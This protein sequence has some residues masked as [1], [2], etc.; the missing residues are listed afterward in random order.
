MYPTIGSFR[1]SVLQVGPIVGACVR[2]CVR[3]LVYVFV[4]VYAHAD[5]Y[6]CTYAQ[7]SVTRFQTYTVPL[8]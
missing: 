8:K 1:V 4:C 7:V 5:V 6:E 3:A 2:L